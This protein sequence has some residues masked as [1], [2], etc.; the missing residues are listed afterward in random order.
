MLCRSPRDETNF[1]FGAMII[2]YYDNFMF[3]YK[4]D[5]IIRY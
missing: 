2:Y 5:T 1:F 4:R 3:D